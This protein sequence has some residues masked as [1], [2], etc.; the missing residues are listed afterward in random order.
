MLQ[1]MGD[2]SC[3]ERRFIFPA[4]M[5]I[6]CFGLI[7]TIAVYCCFPDL[8]NTPGKILLSLSGSLLIAYS[9]LAAIQVVGGNQKIPASVCFASGKSI[10]SKEAFVPI[11]IFG[12]L[13][14]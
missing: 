10:G 6:S 4:A 2:E 11:Y 1:Y 5:F 8:R 12:H 13:F 14:V 9:I 3:T 7:V